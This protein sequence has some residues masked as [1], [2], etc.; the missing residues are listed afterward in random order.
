MPTSLYFV[1]AVL[2]LMPLI[3]DVSYFH[4]TPNNG[5]NRHASKGNAR[6]HSERIYKT[7]MHNALVHNALRYNARMHNVR[8]QNTR[9][10]HAQYAYLPQAATRSEQ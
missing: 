5:V 4:H 6:M 10:Y 7:R 8:M 9:M 1:L 2:R 3:A